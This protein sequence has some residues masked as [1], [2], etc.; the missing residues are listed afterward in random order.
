[1]MPPPFLARR[2]PG[3]ARLRFSKRQP[4]RI[5][6][7]GPLFARPLTHCAPPAHIYQAIDRR[8]ADIP[9]T[10][11]RLRI[12]FRG[13]AAGAWRSG[14]ELATARIDG[15]SFAAAAKFSA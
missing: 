2:R 4:T 14:V 15:N 8:R 6:F 1:M 9:A 7:T 10:L 12:R 3:N 11:T 5:A 13:F